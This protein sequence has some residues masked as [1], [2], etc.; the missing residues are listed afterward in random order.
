MT[1]KAD[2]EDYCYEIIGK[3][4]DYIVRDTQNQMLDNIALQLP[5]YF[6][7]IANSMKGADEACVTG[8]VEL[9][10]KEAKKAMGYYKKAKKMLAEPTNLQEWV[11]EAK[12]VFGSVTVL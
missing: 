1:A 9:T 6:E 8:N 2:D 7:A 3:M 12:K 10:K 5:R 11:E 4:I